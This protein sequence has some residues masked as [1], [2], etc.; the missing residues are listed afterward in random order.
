MTPQARLARRLERVMGVA[1]RLEVLVSIR[2]RNAPLEQQLAAHNVIHIGRRTPATHPILD[3]RALRMPAEVAGGDPLPLRTVTALA[4]RAAGSF[5]GSSVL[6]AQPTALDHLGTARLDARGR[7]P[8]RTQCATPS[9]HP[10]WGMRGDRL[11]LVPSG[12]RVLS[13]AK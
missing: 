11:I 8:P 9:R 4:R 5:A 1:E 12:K 6:R 10:E 2:V 3:P 7:W 13:P